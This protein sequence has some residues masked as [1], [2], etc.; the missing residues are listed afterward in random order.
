M[1]LLKREISIIY[2][3]AQKLSHKVFVHIFVKY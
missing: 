2:R 1:N 3:V